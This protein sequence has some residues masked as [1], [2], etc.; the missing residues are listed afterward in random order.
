[1]QNGFVK[2]AQEWIKELGLKPSSKYPGKYDC[3]MAICDLDLSKI[4]LEF[5][6]VKGLVVGSS[7]S[8]CLQNM[9]QEVV[10]CFECNGTGLNNLDN[11]PKRIGDKL[12]CHDNPFDNLNGLKAVKITLAICFWHTKKCELKYW[13]RAMYN[14]DLDAL[15]WHYDNH[16]Y[17]FPDGG[18]LRKYVNDELE[19][20]IKLKRIKRHLNL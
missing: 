6:I 8:G 16:E 10:G 20:I 13:I 12:F 4:P 15:E 18:K 19:E 9:P 1:M 11:L 7:R 17:W 2:T 14:T 5:G 3:D